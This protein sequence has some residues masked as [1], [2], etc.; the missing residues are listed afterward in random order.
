MKNRLS[1]NQ[2]ITYRAVVIVLFITLIVVTSRQMQADTGTCN[3]ASLTLPFTDVPSSN[4][5]FCAIASA[6]FTGLT[7][8]TSAT[9]Y[10]PAA[11]VTR[12][13]MAAFITRTLD[14]SLRRGNRRAA[15][16][17]WWTPQGSSAVPQFP[18]GNSPYGVACDGADLWVANNVG[19]V[20]RVR[21]SDGKLLGTWT[22]AEDAVDV[23]V[24]RGQIYVIGATSP[25]RLY[26]IDPTQPPGAMTLV[27]N[28]VGDSPKA[29]AFDGKR[30][31][32]I[33]IDGSVTIVSFES[34]CAP[35]CVVTVSVG[36]A[37]L[38]GILYDGANIWVADAGDDTLKKLNSNGSIAQTVSVDINGR[39]VFDGMNIWAPDRPNST[40]TVVRVKDAQGNPL[41]NP[42]V[43]ATLTG[44]GL[45]G[46]F[47]AAFDGERILVTNETTIGNGNTVSLWK[48]ADLTP[49]SF[50]AVTTTLSGVNRVC[51][52][53]VNFWITLQ[54]EDTLA[55]F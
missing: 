40:V 27:T 55:R 15:L 49:L 31:W 52:D 50:F 5:F 54:N 10:S 45:N 16:N 2:H 6:Y 21:A 20:S 30:I 4:L 51:S 14:Q 33:N 41:A 29:I 11:N 39:P 28:S 18:A 19:T 3:G 46:P 42:F 47:A 22:G 8:G 34:V 1:A 36:F 32:T 24:A 23:V 12:E 35:G 53:G 37:S 44:N 48:A 26:R 43:L 25:G 9:T 17:Q 7:N 13:Q 38:Q